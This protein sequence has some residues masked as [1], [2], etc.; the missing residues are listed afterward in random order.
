MLPTKTTYE[1]DENGVHLAL[2]FM[3]PLLPDDLMIASRPITYLT[4][5]AT[6]TSGE[7][8]VAVYVDA[9]ATLAVNTPE[10]KVKIDRGVA[11]D[12]TTLRV[13]TVEQPVLE[14][15][16]DD[17]RIDWGYFYL[18]G[19]T[20]DTRLLPAGVASSAFAQNGQAAQ[21]DVSTDGVAAS[22][23]PVLSMTFPLDKVATE[24][25]S[26]TA[27]LAYDDV[28]S[29]RY[30][31]SDLKGYWTKDGTTFEQL[32][33]K[34][35]KEHDALAKRADAFD[36]D[37]VAA[38]TKIG[39]E[40]YVQ[41]G[42]LAYRQSLAAQK[43]CADANG[44]PIMMSK[45][46]FSN[47]CIG[48]VDV[49]Y[50]ASPLMLTFSPNMMKASLQPLL[51]YSASPRWKHDSAPH[52]MGTYPI[53]TGQVYGGGDSDSGMPVEESGNM[54]CMLGALAKVEGN[55]TFS[56][57]YWPTLTK[58][59][60]YLK[61]KGFDPG[62]QL[63]T[64]DFAGHIARNAN[65]SA[66]AIMGVASYAMLAD[67]LGR[68]DVAEQYMQAAKD[69]A[70]Q[71]MKLAADGDHYGLVF[72]DK[73]KGTWSQK[74]NL[75]WDRILDFNIFPKE[76]YDKEMAFY[77]TKMNK[78]GLP[79]DSRKAYTKLDWEVWTGT[80]ADKHEDFQTIVDA[81]AKWTN[82]TPDRAPMGDWYGT[83]KGKKEGFQARSVVGGLFLP[84]MTDPALW[85][86]FA[87]ERQDAG[88]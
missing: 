59:A 56:E 70:Q 43:I 68:K 69:G 65:L 32:L 37:L 23:A 52:D 51:D 75:V 83:I 85:K 50:P 86:R 71:W 26:A 16:G 55:A 6:S 44:Q 80:L 88:R 28:Y 9:A 64:D 17:R 8:D 82:E 15:K 54:L 13:G 34:A 81:C 67:M 42:V 2:S 4:W 60:D 5:T 47:G 72:G 79:L 31:N 40:S 87:S 39:G 76:V 63:T 1:F 29:L 66:K 62:N 46:N 61:N 19:K 45:E 33:V 11:G 74:Y 27:I 20:Q 24:A 49:L 53:A 36:Q 3:T 58:W 77:M 10:Q 14:S 30:F 25:Q 21:A 18:A 48:T 84:F 7:H 78:F 73:G 41:L 35:D 22:N 38:M 12:L 57:R